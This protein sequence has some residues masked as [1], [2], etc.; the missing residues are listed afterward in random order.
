[1]TIPPPR[2]PVGKPPKIVKDEVRAAELMEEMRQADAQIR[3]ATQRRLHL[4][5][6]ANE[7]GMTVVKI[8]EAVGV[9]GVAVSKW[10]RA[11]RAKDPNKGV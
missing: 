5:H 8:G 10:I 2:R 6:E 4:A 1:M 11:A 9:S 3:E 7:L